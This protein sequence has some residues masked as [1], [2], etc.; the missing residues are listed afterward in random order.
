MRLG[1]LADQAELASFIA[2]GDFGAEQ[3]GQELFVGAALAQGLVGG[4]AVAVADGRQVQGPAGLID[5]GVEWV[6]AGGDAAGAGCA[7]SCGRR[8]GRA[9]AVPFGVRLSSRS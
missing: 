3:V 9:H 7:R 5:G 6:V 1:R 2:V 4:F 8:G